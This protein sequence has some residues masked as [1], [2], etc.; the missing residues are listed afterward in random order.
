MGTNVFA[1]EISVCSL[2]V[3]FHSLFSP[4]LSNLPILKSMKIDFPAL[5]DRVK[6]LLVIKFQK[7]PNFDLKFLLDV[8]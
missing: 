5:Q 4:I 2:S 8:R 6:V 7:V 1:E 3:C